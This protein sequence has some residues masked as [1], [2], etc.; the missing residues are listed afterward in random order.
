MAS[1][2]PAR[3]CQCFLH[4]W[5]GGSVS[6]APLHALRFGSWR[7]G[8]ADDHRTRA[9]PLSVTASASPRAQQ[10]ATH[11]AHGLGAIWLA[12]LSWLARRR[13]LMRRGMGRRDA[14]APA[15]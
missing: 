12:W 13:R 10:P 14:L 3:Q 8:L 6:R 9:R 11:P 2:E 5:L 7:A 15:P 4:F 1:A